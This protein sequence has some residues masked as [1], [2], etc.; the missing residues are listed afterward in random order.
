MP[1]Q[2]VSS[3]EA[4]IDTLTTDI[5]ALNNQISTK[6]NNYNVQKNKIPSFTAGYNIRKKK[7][8]YVKAKA[9]KAGKKKKDYQC[10]DNTFL[11]PNSGGC[12]DRDHWNDQWNYWAGEMNKYLTLLNNHKAVVNTLF[13]ELNGFKGTRDDKIIERDKAIAAKNA[14]IK[15]EA[16][17]VLV[18]ATAEAIKDPEIVKAGLEAETAKKEAVLASNRKMLINSLAIL[19]FVIIAIIGIRAVR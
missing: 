8:E 1:T 3:L 12:Y 17:A 4:Q 10:Y 16:D 7:Y 9:K 5:T 15:A 14:L 2:S 19:A 11:F 18:I 6:L 13:S